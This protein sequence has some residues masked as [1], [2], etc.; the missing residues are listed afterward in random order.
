MRSLTRAAL[1][2]LLTLLVVPVRAQYRG[3][4]VDTFN[5]PLN[6]RADVVA[7]VESVK[8]AK[9]NAIFVQ[10]RRRGDSWYRNSLEPLADRTPIAAGFD[11][12]ADLIAEAHAAGIE[13]HAFVIVG[14]I[15]NSIPNGASAR[16]PEDPNHVFNRHGFN[17]AT[18]RLHEGRDNWLTRTLLPD[19]STITFNGHRVGGDFWIDLGHPDAAQHTLDVLLHL[20]RN[21]DLD[22]LHLD[23]IRYPDIAGTLAGGVSSGYNETN[24]ARFQRRYGITVGSAPPAAN[25]PRWS[26]WRRDQVTNFVRRVYLNAIAIRPRLRVSAA[27]IAYGGGPASES[28]WNNAEA[29]WRVFQDWRAWTEEGILDFAIPMVYKR[30]HVAAQLAQFDSWMEWTKN[31]AYARGVMMGT[32]SYLNSIE[33]TLRQIRRSLAANAQGNRAGGVVFFSHAVTNE[34]VAANPLSIPAGR[35]TP[36]RSFAEFAAGLTTG[37]S[38]D[39]QTAYEDASANP[40]PVFSGSA[41]IP[42]A[43]W[44]TNPTAGHVM[45]IVRRGNGEAVDAAEVR[46][47]RV[48]DG[49][50]PAG[51]RA[52]AT[53]ATDGNGF[54]GA[55]DLAPGRYRVTVL[56]PGEP[57]V[58][59]AC[60]PVVTAGQVSAF[61]I[62]ADR[63]LQG[64]VSVSAGSYCGPQLAPGSIIAA[65]GTGLA[66][67]LQIAA[68]TPLPT[69]LGATSV[70]LRDSAN[71]ERLSPL[72]FVSPGQV[73]YL[74]PEEAA[75]GPATVTVLNGANQFSGSIQVARVAP[76]LFTANADGSGAPAAIALRILAGGT[77][78]TEPVVEFDAARNR[79]VPRPIDLGPEGEQVYLILFATGLR[80]RSSL[81]G[82]A[83]RIGGLPADVAYAGPQGGLVGLDQLN[84][85]LPRTLAG[86]G[87]VEIVLLVD[88][89]PAN[90]VRI[91]VK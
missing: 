62:T 26:Q 79:F 15:W 51:G 40:T 56:A 76:A 48:E 86:R 16:P 32:G 81:A 6:N 84:I 73:N 74:L 17:Q 91:N 52:S 50:T 80:Q 19:D 33:G 89:Y 14:A 30:D 78:I 59:P 28:D 47:V 41:A 39:G 9:C 8:R 70:R 83:A 11:P 57:G 13:V 88:N 77:Q 35:D 46:I 54:Y 22:G 18:G 4:W 66:A 90:V 65:F 23:R 31:H 21:Y 64:A 75:I 36:R 20:V 58:M 27:L 85:P 7:L 87:E 53:T 42:A 45:G 24:V 2:V 82:V 10:A 67:D 43:P 60:A 69:T 55:V 72:F 29:Y 63:A 34:A 71:V 49:T 5:T 68:T 44:K 37:R 12:L 38:A 1:L 3:F 61:D 25:D